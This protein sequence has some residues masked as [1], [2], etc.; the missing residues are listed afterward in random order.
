MLLKFYIV[1]P[2]FYLKQIFLTY[3]KKFTEKV[4]TS[5]CLKDF[6]IDLK[7]YYFKQKDELEVSRVPDQRGLSHGGKKMVKLLRRRPV[8]DASVSESQVRSSTGIKGAF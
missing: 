1:I 4:S 7:H 5:Q 3:S 8:A 2:D 6:Y